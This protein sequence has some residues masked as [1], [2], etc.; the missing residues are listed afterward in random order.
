M[1]VVVVVVVV[2]QLKSLLTLS[3]GED[4]PNP[5]IIPADMDTTWSREPFTPES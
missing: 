1:V 5:A 4:G 2:T 3:G